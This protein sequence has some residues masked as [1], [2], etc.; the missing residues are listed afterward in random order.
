GLDRFKVPTHQQKKCVSSEQESAASSKNTF[1]CSVSSKS[2]KTHAGDHNGSEAQRP[3]KRN[4]NK[5]WCNDSAH[6]SRIYYKTYNDGMERRSFNEKR[7]LSSLEEKEPK[8]AVH[9]LPPNLMKSKSED[10]ATRLTRQ[11]DADEQM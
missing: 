10:T 2:P 5:A 4:S 11:L 3:E 7:Q 9:A 8:E 1:T 6:Y